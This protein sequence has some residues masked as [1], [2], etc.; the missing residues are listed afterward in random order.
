MEVTARDVMETVFHTLSPETSIAD[1]VKT[2]K[3]VSEEKHRKI[4]GM[5]V[6]NQ[7][8]QLV[9]MLSM[10][11]ILL[12][13]RPKHIHIWGE[14]NGFIDEA[15]NRT[16]SILVGDIMATDVITITPDTH[17][18]MIVDIMLRKHIRRIPV[19]KNDK[20]VGIVYLPQVFYR[21]LNRLVD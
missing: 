4:L 17:I 8:D 9:G 20:V 21:L 14:V 5:M 13:L 6:T 7:Q 3:V 12:L 19:L 18:L 15:C 2:F 1:A 11:D 10:Y 16:K